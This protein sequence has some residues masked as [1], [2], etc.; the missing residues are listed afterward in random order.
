[1]TTEDRHEY[2][3]SSDLDGS[4]CAICRDRPDDHYEFAAVHPDWFEHACQ[5]ADA[6][7]YVLS[8]ADGDSSADRLVWAKEVLTRYQPTEVSE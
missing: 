7:K 4:P 2:R 8:Y 5:L 1:M 6:L 3:P